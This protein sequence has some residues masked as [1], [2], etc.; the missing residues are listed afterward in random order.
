M[1]KWAE[2]WDWVNGGGGETLEGSPDG[3]GISPLLISLTKFFLVILS[4]LLLLLK[5]QD[6]LSNDHPITSLC[7]LIS[8]NSVSYHRKSKQ[9]LLMVW[10][11]NGATPSVKDRH[12]S[13]GGN[14]EGSTQKVRLKGMEFATMTQ[15]LNYSS[16]RS[17]RTFHILMGGLSHISQMSEYKGPYIDMRQ[18]TPQK[19]QFPLSANILANITPKDN[20]SH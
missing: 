18:S 5:G 14:V 20:V 15:R 10:V 8:N 16:D 1:P 6:S 12:M 7:L 9:D 11:L 4:F 2:G 19:K 13:Q 17:P 3:G